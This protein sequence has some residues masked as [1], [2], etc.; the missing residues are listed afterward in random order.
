MEPVQTCTFQYTLDERDDFIHIHPTSTSPDYNSNKQNRSEVLYFSAISIV[1]P[2]KHI[3]RRILFGIISRTSL[4]SKVLW[5]KN[6]SMFL[7]R[8]QFAE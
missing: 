8:M 6:L 1:D 7:M 3:L 5:V 4:D 2:T